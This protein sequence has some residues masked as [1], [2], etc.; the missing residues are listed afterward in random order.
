MKNGNCKMQI[1]KSFVF[2]HFAF[3]NLHFAFGIEL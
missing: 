3:F 2:S 1:A